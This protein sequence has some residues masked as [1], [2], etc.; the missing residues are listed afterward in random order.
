MAV[1]TSRPDSSVLL[2]RDDTWITVH[3][4][5]EERD[6]LAEYGINTLFQPPYLLHTSE[7]LRALFSSNESFLHRNQA[8]AEVSFS[9]THYFLFRDP[10]AR[11]WK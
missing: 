8:L 9:Q 10:R 1:E 5:A 4:V 3:S 6:M 2:E 7:H 11:A